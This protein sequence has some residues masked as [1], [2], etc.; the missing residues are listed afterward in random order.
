MSR[1]RR[2]VFTVRW[3]ASLA[4]CSILF[5]LLWFGVGAG[6]DDPAGCTY[7]KPA[8]TWQKWRVK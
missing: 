8:V 3:A 2:R 1:L 7:E 4:A 5:G 6:C